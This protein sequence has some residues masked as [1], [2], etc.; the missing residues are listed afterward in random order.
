MLNYFY[1]YILS[2]TRTTYFSERS[3]TVLSVFER[4][5]TY[6]VINIHEERSF[7]FDFIQERSFMLNYVHLLSFAF[8]QFFLR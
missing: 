1:V 4:I 7:T 5:R 6:T 8:N 2:W 3:K